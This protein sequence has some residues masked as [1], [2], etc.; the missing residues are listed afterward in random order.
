MY[1]SLPQKTKKLRGNQT[2]SSTSLAKQQQQQQKTREPMTT[3][4]TAPTAVKTITRPKMKDV[5]DIQEKLICYFQQNETK[6]K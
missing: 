2:A 3:T 6:R 4:N 1:A 5:K